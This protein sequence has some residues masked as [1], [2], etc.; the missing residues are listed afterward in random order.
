MNIDEARDLISAPGQPYEM[1]IVDCFRGSVP[2][3]I[4]GPATLRD[5]FE[6]NLG[7]E[8]F[9]V[10]N[11]ERLSFTNTY[12]KASQIAHVLHHQFDIQK[13]DRVAISMRNYPEW[14]LAFTA[15]TSIGA[16][17]VGM[18]SLWLPD[19]M[20]YGLTDCGAKLLFADEE[21]LERISHVSSSLSLHII[22]V[23]TSRTINRPVFRLE[24]LLL[25][26]PTL[27]MPVANIESNDPAI[28]LYTSGSTGRPKGVVSSQRNILTAILAWEFAAVAQAMSV[29][30]QHD[31][32][33][34]ITPDPPAALLGVPL[35][36]VMGMH[37]VY[38][39]CYRSKRKLVCMYKWDPAQ[40]AELVERERITTFSAPPAMTGDLAR[41]AQNSRR[42]LSSL[43]AVGGGGAARAPEQV[44]QIDSSFTQA[45]PNT[46]WGMT[47]TNAVGTSI[48]GAEYLDHALSAGR[49]L[50]CIQLRVVDEKGNSLPSGERG[51][52]QIRG[53]Q[54]FIGYWN[55]P[56]VDAEVFDGDWFRTGD[57][58]YIDENGYMYIVDRIKDL[59]IRGGE[60]IGCGTVEA[61]LMSHP[62]VVEAV[63]YAIPD[64]RLGEEVAA[65]IFVSSPIEETELRNYLS[66]HLARF[67]IPRYLRISAEPLPRTDSGKIFRRQI[68]DAAIAELDQ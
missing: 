8:T 19:E 7:D 65:T 68:R 4:N 9:L 16:I 40:A 20:E 25:N 46:G 43:L 38:L 55:R 56:E 41:E 49:A 47:E 52:L 24:D 29:Q 11:D 61:A 63:A 21:R 15:I 5:L 33:P 57:V 50:P 34:S 27:E 26:T 44:K 67:E 53:P 32:P 51:E 17:A 37:V 3:F 18:N 45:A 42:D 30:S 58:S 39:S 14:I 28:I 13:G 35:F 31:S 62:A 22:S 2:G 64:E 48:N 12:S 60:N 23:R 1:G 36:H 54:M 66:G 59:I 6:Q 10:Y